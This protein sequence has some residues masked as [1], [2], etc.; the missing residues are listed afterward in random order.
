MNEAHVRFMQKEVND[1]LGAHIPQEGDVWT[2]CRRQ[3]NER[4]QADEKVA[5]A[6]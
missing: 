2:S 3:G 1:L 4:R 6:E 5:V